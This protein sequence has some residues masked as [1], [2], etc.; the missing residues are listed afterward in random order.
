M[1]VRW[2]DGADQDRE[3]IVGYI[4]LDNPSA[5][6][7]VD[8]M[9]DD[10]TSRLSKFPRLGKDGAIPGTRELLPH[11]NYRLVYQIRDAEIIVLALIHTARQWPP[12]VED[13]P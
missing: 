4:W 12:A 7:R 13:Q 6:R 11:P 2:S 1:R 10:A 3:D 9:F 5:A 8:A